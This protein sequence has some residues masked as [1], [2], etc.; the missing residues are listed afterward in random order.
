MV[1]TDTDL[2]VRKGHAQEI[3]RQAGHS[4]GGWTLYRG[5][6]V[7]ASCQNEGCRADAFMDVAGGDPRGTATRGDT[8]RT[9]CPM[10]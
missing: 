3:A 2:E 8:L 9:K 6:V 5:K 10:S 7:V 1:R 4:I